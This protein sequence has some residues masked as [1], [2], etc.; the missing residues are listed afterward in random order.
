MA[1]PV[2][3]AAVGALVMIAKGDLASVRAATVRQF[4]SLQPLSTSS[5]ERILANVWGAS[6]DPLTNVVDVY[7]GRLRAKIDEGSVAPLIHT[8]RGLGYRLEVLRS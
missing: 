1:P 6:E 8:V 5:R 7:I 3:F 2:I 4:A